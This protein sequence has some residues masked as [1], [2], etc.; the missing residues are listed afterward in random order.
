ME[1]GA[2]LLAFTT[3]QAAEIPF[4]VAGAYALHAYTGLY[5]QTKDL[6][7]FLRRQDVQRAREALEAV[8]FRTEMVDP[9]W[10]AK[11]HASNA[12]FADLIFCSGNGIAEVDDIWFERAESYVI[13]GLPVSVAPP[14]EMIW[15]KAFVAERE[16]YDGADVNHIVFVRGDQMDWEHLLW[17]FGEHWPVLFSHLVLYRFAYP[18]HRDRVPEWVW[19]E[20]LARAQSLENEPEKAA[21][22]RGTLLSK[23][24]YRIDLDHWG[25]DDAR[26]VEVKNFRD[27]YREGPDRGGG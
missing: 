19:R 25:F 23:S 12:Y 21:L 27:H 8:N 18:G 1:R 16:R 11:A 9:V 5:R 4:V 14:E 26:I 15:S 22:C 13:H 2:H 10:I 24:Q 7:I 3:L 6:D 20:L 17:R